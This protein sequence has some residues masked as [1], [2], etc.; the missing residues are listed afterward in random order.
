MRVYEYESYD[1]YVKEQIEANHKKLHC[2][3]AS[4]STMMAISRR[5][6]DRTSIIC[7]GSRRGTEIDYFKQAYPD[8]HVIGTDISDTATQFDNQFEWDFHDVNEYWEGKFDLVYS[9]SFDHAYDPHK[10]L[11]TW[12]GQ[13]TRKGV[14]CIELMMGN[15]NRSSKMDPTEISSDEL[16]DLLNDRGLKTIH[17]F[18]IT[19]IHGKSLCHIAEKRENT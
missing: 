17:K 11:D 14:L 4:L 12:V 16:V 1:E 7:H 2:T 13:L 8:A 5:V 10:A 18:D 3:W 9:N 15:D 6:K 19:A